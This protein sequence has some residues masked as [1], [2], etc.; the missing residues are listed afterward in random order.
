MSYIPPIPPEIMSRYAN[1]TP[2]KAAQR[3]PVNLADK[4]QP[5]VQKKMLMWL[6]QKYI[7]PQAQERRAFEGM[8]D[9]MLEMARITIPYDDLFSDTRHDASKVKNAAAQGNRD[10]ARVSDSVVHDAIQRLT[11]I[12]YFIAFKEGLPCQFAIPD[13]IKQ[14]M[15]TQ[16]YRPLKDRIS[17]GN[18]LLQW[19][20]GNH[21]VKRGSLITYRHHY[22]YGCAFVMSD[23][24]FRVEMINRQDNAGNLVPM[25]EITEIGTTFEP[26][27]IRKCWFNW[28]LPVYDMDS[29]PCP[30]FMEETPRFAVMENQYDPVNNPF[31]YVNLDKLLAGQFIYSE[32]ETESVRNAL[33]ITFNSMGINDINASTLAQILQPEYSVEAKWT[34]FPVMPFDPV[35]GEFETRAD[36][37]PIPFKRF[38]METFG[39][40]IHSGSQVILRLQENYYPKRRLPIYASSHMPD[41]DSG[42][43]A[44]SIGQILYNHYKELVLCMEQFLENKDLINDTP[45]WVQTSSPSR[46]SDL[47]AKGAKILVNGPNDFGYKTQ[48]DGT[49]STAAILQMLRDQAQTTGKV[50]DA[51]LGK[52]MG[53]RTSATEASNAFQA[54]MSSI[55]TDIDMVS[56]DIHG[57][58][59]HRVWDYSGA[60][61]D[62]DLL[63]HITGQFG[64]MISPEDMWMNVGVITNV[65]STYV[66]KIVKQQNTRYILEA[67]KM[68]PGLDRA[69]LWK[70]LL[71]DMGFDGGSIVDDG[72]REQ[73]I[74]FATQQACQTFLGYPIIV[75]PDQDHQL[76]I[77]VKSSFIKDQTSVWMTTPEY[78]RNAPLLIEQIKVHQMIF[79]LQQQMLLVQQQMAVAQAQ[80]KV[81]QENPPDQKPQPGSRNAGPPAQQAGQVAQQGA[82]AA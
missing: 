18:A 49:S 22:T 48:V 69:E 12:T 24:K 50:V 21:N 63:Q 45:A 16:E 4:I 57:N 65:G 14:P 7:W 74:Q 15:A 80:L 34:M 81:H 40:N 61:F 9:K 55:T 19:N 47:N 6:N 36:G 66:E 27:S 39:P 5:D 25:P 68:E 52:A 79:Q 26:I 33:K 13:Y 72:G 71:D 53:S 20:S 1:G 2:A 43:Y 62:P 82:S 30:F 76:A 31:G 78:A 32:P 73:Q 11:D 3:F 56:Q 41:L 46:N 75:D 23:F 42:A 10:K 8:W 64:F 70:M 77:R 38:V 60:W 28:R 51:V 17:A 44:P 35:T 54:S 59:A 29:Q 58:Y 37:K 67:S